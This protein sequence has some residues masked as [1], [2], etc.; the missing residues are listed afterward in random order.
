MDITELILRQHADQRSM[1]AA[2]EEWPREDTAGLGSLWRRLEIMLEVHA[3]AEE[4][5]FYPELTRLGTGGGDADSVE[6]EVKDA[7]KDH[8]EIRD[9]IAK[10]AA[11]QVGSDDWYAAI[12][13][14]NVAN[15]D[16]MAEEERQDLTDFRQHAT[17]DLRHRLAVDF[18]RFEAEHWAGGVRAVDRDPDEFV[19]ENDGSRQS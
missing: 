10:V 6:G 3:L 8:N 15:G 16:H 7:I 2:L 5:F 14:V 1:F 18:L 4:R 12:L 9:G 19:R 11:A 17:L 13:E